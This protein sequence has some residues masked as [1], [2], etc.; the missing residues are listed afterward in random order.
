MISIFGRRYFIQT[1]F[2]GNNTLTRRRKFPIEQKWKLLFWNCA[3]N[4]IWKIARFQSAYGVDGDLCDVYSGFG[5]KKVEQMISRGELSKTLR[6]E[7]DARDKITSRACPNFFLRS[8]DTFLGT[9]GFRT[10]HALNG[11]N[12]TR[13]MSFIGYFL[14]KNRR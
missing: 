3:S 14:H 6:V 2:N 12:G 4:E 9:R 10:F 5:V 1:Q 13:L 8:P 7:I 11:Q